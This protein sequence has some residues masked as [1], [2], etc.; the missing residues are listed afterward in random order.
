MPHVLRFLPG[1]SSSEHF[2][3]SRSIS[4]SVV[5]T[6]LSFT[7]FYN[8]YGMIAR[9]PFNI[10]QQIFCVCVAVSWLG[11]CARSTVTTAKPRTSSHTHRERAHSSSKHYLPEWIESRHHFDSISPFCLDFLHNMFDYYHYILLL[12]LLYT[13][14]K[15]SALHFPHTSIILHIWSSPRVE[16]TNERT[17]D[18]TVYTFANKIWIWAF[19]FCE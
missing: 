16:W 8:C 14:S 6:R 3:F 5:C 11:M 7:I 13:L 15:H 12:L 19:L 10:S 2:S 17:N 4:C 1:I 18:Q 9:A